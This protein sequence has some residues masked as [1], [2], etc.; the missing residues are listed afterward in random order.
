MA[1]DLSVAQDMSA[2]DM[3]VACCQLSY[4]GGPNSYVVPAPGGPHPKGLLPPP[5]PPLLVPWGC[6]S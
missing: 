2:Q 5:L 3:L 1:P 4:R 6:Q